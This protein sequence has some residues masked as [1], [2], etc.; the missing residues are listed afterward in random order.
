MKQARWPIAALVCTLLAPAAARAE[1]YLAVK[2]GFKCMQ[3]HVN[4]TGGGMRTVFGNAYAQSQLAA[5][6]LDTGAYGQWTDALRNMILI[7][8][9][10]RA[11]YHYTGIPHEKS[12]NAF[13]TEEIRAYIAAN[14]IPDHLMVYADQSL[15]PN[16]SDNREAY[17]RL[18]A[19]QSRYYLKAGHMYLPYGWRLQD[20]SAFIRE[21]PGINYQTPD[22]G[23]ELG[24]EL[25]NWSAQLAVTNGTSG[26]SERDQ[27]KQYSL[28]GEYVRSFW[29]LGVSGNLNDSAAGRRRM[30]NVFAG[31]RT[32]PI[33]WLGEADYIVDD[34]FPIGRRKLWAG[35][36][37]ANW[38]WR[39]GHNVKLTGE[40]FDPDTKV[41]H[42]Q[43]ARY[44]LLYEYTPI[45]FLQVRGGVR[46]YDG[47]PQNN[48][49]NRKLVFVELHGF[50]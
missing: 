2:E 3:C 35:L 18:S 7:G 42:D 22:N 23:A 17:V 36:L 40:Y 47:I 31:L 21:V 8:G 9:D 39:Q 26:A 30:G 12:E 46:W 32:G 44:S 41:R 14:V 6:R 34:G 11:N 24:L 38:G 43:Q 20:D 15:G 45:Q 33:A 50:F 19:A 48:L 1:P 37:E 16:G 13:E 29:R 5:Q 49:Q 10:L 28:R 4:P 25:P 27:G